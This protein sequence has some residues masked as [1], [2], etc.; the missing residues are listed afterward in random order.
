VF[1]LSSGKVMRWEVKKVKRWELG[2]LQVMSRGK[3]MN[4]S[5]LCK[6][7]F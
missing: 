2:L 3:E 1:A 5:V 4:R 6:S 7:E